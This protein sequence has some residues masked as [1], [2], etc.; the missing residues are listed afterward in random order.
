MIKYCLCASV[1]SFATVSNATASSLSS[2][3]FIEIESFSSSP[4]MPI[5]QLKD[6][7]KG[8]AATQGDYILS[9]SRVETGLRTKLFTVS[10]LER[11]EFYAEFT[12]DTAQIF[13]EQRNDVDSARTRAY[14]VDLYGF[15]FKAS[16]AK[17]QLPLIRS[18]EFGLS[19]AGTYYEASKMQQGVLKGTV[20]TVEDIQGYLALDYSYTSDVFFSREPESEVNGYG[21]SVDVEGWWAPSE[22]TRVMFFA[23]DLHSNVRWRNQ[24]HTEASATTDTVRYNG[25]GRIE[26]RPAIEW[27]ESERSVTQK[28]PRYYEISVARNLNDQWAL[29]AIVERYESTTILTLEAIHKLTESQ[30]IAV[31]VSPSHNALGVHYHSRYLFLGVSSDR[32]Y[33]DKVRN[34]NLSFG[35]NVPIQF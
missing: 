13:Q 9:S 6:N 29:G 28:L 3:Y 34:F 4:T 21:Y 33:W 8:P 16:G 11:M 14:D 5:K 26:A 10:I 18:K 12:N 24:Q 1:L 23:K 27:F 17:L 7:L 20:Y 32:F 15:F 25:D 22:H 2:E 30:S 19:M 31:N 35:V